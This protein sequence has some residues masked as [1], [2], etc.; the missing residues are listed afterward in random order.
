MDLQ[1]IKHVNA[2]RHETAVKLCVNLA[3][4]KKSFRMLQEAIEN[5]TAISMTSYNK[6]DKDIAS[7]RKMKQTAEESWWVKKAKA[8]L[9][10]AQAR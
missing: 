5:S 8:T 3:D 4:I 1:G 9:N 2:Y 7:W 6:P 10:N